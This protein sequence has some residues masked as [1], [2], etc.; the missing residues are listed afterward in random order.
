M[1]CHGD[2]PSLVDCFLV[3]QVYNAERF[4][5][6]LEPYPRIREIAQRCRAMD[7]FSRA[8]HENQPDAEK[9]A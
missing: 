5:C 1:Y 7:A 6:D 4:S 8:A 9:L 3:P 2:S